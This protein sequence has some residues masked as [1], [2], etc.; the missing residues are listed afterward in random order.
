M[1]LLLHICCAPCSIYPVR[2]LRL[3]NH[4]ITGFFYNSN[5]HPYTE[6][7]KRQEALSQYA[8]QIDLT[9]VIA[10]TYDMEG[11]LRAVV[12]RETERCRYCYYD[13]LL[14]TAAKAKR[15]GFDAFST[16]L[17]YSK[18]QKHNEIQSIGEA[19]GHEIGLPFYYEDFRAGW[20]EGVQTSKK[21]GIYRQQYCGC[22]YSEKERYCRSA[23]RKSDIKA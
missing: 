2:A 20:K 12:F 14:T 18:F 10:D 11:F 3:N 6:Y 21:M 13:R 8:R 5:I 9:V 19:V 4:D 23:D 22:I 17:L 7:Q 16:T 1:N 15:S